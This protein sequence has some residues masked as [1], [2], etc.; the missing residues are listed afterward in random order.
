MSL[1]PGADPSGAESDLTGPGERALTPSGLRRLS[2]GRLPPG[3]FIDADLGRAGL[4]THT[5]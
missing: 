3:R 4:I 2:V 1:A 5:L